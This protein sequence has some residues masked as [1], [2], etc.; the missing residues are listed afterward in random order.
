MIDDKS[1]FAISCGL[2]IIGVKGE[3]GLGGCVADAL[4]Q[5]TAT[6]PTLILCS[7]ARTNT[8]AIIKATGTFSVSVLCKDVDPLLIAN[9]GFVSARV[10]N[11]WERVEQQEFCGL[12]T[13]KECVARYA[14][15]VI[16]TYEMGSHTLFHA[17][18][19]GAE[20]GSGAALSYG[21][22]REHIKDKTVKAFQEWRQKRQA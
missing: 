12:P 22:Y 16:F 13:L 15:Q 6:P 19:I 4:I 5:A 18:V 17:N 2:F 1:L 3:G 21:Y 20:M 9:F 11:K 8:N 10:S 7:G 14:C